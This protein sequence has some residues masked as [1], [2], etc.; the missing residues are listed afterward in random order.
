[1]I[2]DLVCTLV[3][4]Q[5]VEIL[6]NYCVIDSE[7][8]VALENQTTAD[9]DP[10][11]QPK[12]VAWM[13]GDFRFVSFLL[14]CPHSSDWAPSLNTAINVVLSLDFNV[15]FGLYPLQNRMEE[16]KA[17]FRTIITYP[18]FQNSSIILF[19]NKKDL[20]EEK[21]M[22]SHLVEYFPEFDGRF[23]DSF[24]T[25]MYNGI[26]ENSVNKNFIHFRLEWGKIAPNIGANATEFFTLTTK[27]WKL[28]SKWLATLISNLTLPRELVIVEDL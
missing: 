13:H 16:S 1:M 7:T 17:L 23:E 15:H 2:V 24:V 28:V 20:L 8:Q 27:S 3:N 25:C 10:C 22:F 21:I 4:C 6:R 9:T 11:R 19:L 18:W 5:E 12:K 14:C 26:C